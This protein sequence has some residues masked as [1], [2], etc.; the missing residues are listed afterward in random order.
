VRSQSPS[1]VKAAALLVVQV[2][3]VPEL[4]ESRYLCTS[5]IRFVVLPSRLV[6]LIRAPPEPLEMKAPAEVKSVPGSRILLLVAPALRMAVTASWTV[7]AHVLMLRSC[8]RVRSVCFICGCGLD[9]AY[10]FVHQTKGNLVVALVLSRNLRPQAG[11]L[12]VCRSALANNSTVPAGVVV[13]VNNAK[14]SAGVQAA[15]DHLV[16]RGPVGGVEGAAEVVVEQELPSD[17]NAE[18]VQ[19]V[20]LDEVLYLVDADLARVDDAC[21]LT[22]SVDGAAEVET[23]DLMEVVG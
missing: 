4:S 7:V 6:T 3:C 11:E 13:D 19:A 18:G 23:S 15:L 2:V 1:D 8:W 14:R 16:V 9:F 20:V 17:R 10:R 5:K 21:C 12:G 22:S